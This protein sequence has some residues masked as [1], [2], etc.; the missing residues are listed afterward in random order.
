MEE[1]CL[2]LESVSLK[3]KEASGFEILQSGPS[4]KDL[5]VINPPAVILYLFSRNHLVLDRLWLFKAF[6]NISVSCLYKQPHFKVSFSA[7]YNS[8]YN[9]PSY[10]RIL[11]GSCL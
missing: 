9:N 10:S 8:L 4:N 5:V 6:T 3:L 7:F 2:K 1:C 11:I